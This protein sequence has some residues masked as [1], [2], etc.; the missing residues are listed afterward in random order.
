MNV[1]SPRAWWRVVLVALVAIA[2][3]GVAVAAY[4]AKEKEPIRRVVYGTTEPQNAPGQSLVLQQV[5][6]DPGA[7]LPEHFHEGTQLATIKAG[8]LT[9]NVVSGSVTVMHRDGTSETL[10]APNTV[11]LRVGDTIVEPESLVHY[12][13]N[14]GKQ[15]VVIELAALLH[16]GA[17]LSTA[18]GTGA[19][20]DTI[21]LETVLSSQART[22]YQT[23]PGNESTYGW[24]RLTGT[25]T[26]N[27]Q[28][29]SIEMLA[30]VDYTKGNGPFSGVIT[31]TF[32]DGSTLGVS[33]TGS[34]TAQPNGTDASFAS[35]LG[36]IG[37]TGQYVNTTGSGVFNGTRSAALGTD[38]GAVFTLQL[39]P[40]GN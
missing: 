9:Y 4:A 6:I 8:I 10:D 27:G 17:P 5:V 11:K 32:A 29:V 26:L 7:K 37:G 34:T 25:S 15:T 21:K 14:D 18:V 19:A 20:G 24:N 1:R 16:D 13:A 31:F 3:V 23:G 39:R 30:T 2:V 38:V 36:V 35:T 12:G 33:M 22:L 28:P 40:K